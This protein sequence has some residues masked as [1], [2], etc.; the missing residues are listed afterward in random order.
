M[1]RPATCFAVLCFALAAIP[2][3]AQTADNPPQ[4]KGGPRVIVTDRLGQETA[5]RLVNWTGSSIVIRTNG[6]ERTYASG[7]AI[8]V[9]LR[10]DSLKNGFLIGAAVGSLGGL[11]SDCPDSRESCAGSRV[12]FTI[13]SMGIWGAIGAGIDALIPGRSPLWRAGPSA[14][15]ASGPTFDVSVRERRAAIGWRFVLI[16]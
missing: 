5:G 13:V 2:A 7:E 3:G 4:L 14:N 12:A 11:A 9:D 16:Q 6:I 8:R 15:S 10:N 1:A